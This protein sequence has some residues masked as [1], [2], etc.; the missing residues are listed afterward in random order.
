ML[1]V[2]DVPI[3]QKCKHEIDSCGNDL[4]SK[5]S[6][7]YQILAIAHSFYDYLCVVARIW[8]KMRSSQSNRVKSEVTR[9]ELH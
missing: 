7:A 6:I 1:V 9:A 5:R 8:S 2:L 3:K 4:Q